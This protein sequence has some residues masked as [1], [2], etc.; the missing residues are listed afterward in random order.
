MADTLRAAIDSVLEQEIEGRRV[1][2]GSRRDVDLIVVVDDIDSKTR[3]VL[4][5][6]GD[7]LRWCLGDARGQAAAVNKGLTQLDAEIVK[8]LNADDILLP[9]A[10]E[11][12]DRT[13]GRNRDIDFVY[14]DIVFLDSEGHRRG[15]HREP[16][17]SYFILV[18]GHNL[19]ADPACF[20]RKTLHDRIGMISEETRYSLDYE[21][22]VRIARAGRRVAQVRKEIAA[23]AVTGINMT[24]VNHKAMR[25]EHYDVLARHS[26][27]W[28]RMPRG[29]RNQMLAGLLILARAWKKLRTTFE[30]GSLEFGTFNRLISSARNASE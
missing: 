30:R 8:W 15:E 7:C 13:F 26:V 6:Y 24:V 27:F 21:F 5:S 18:Y 3:S 14:G 22:W 16:A 28:G 12:M 10:L 2:T 4:T 20:W 23:Y 29:L 19:F 17:Y 25:N 1:N 9:G 11:A